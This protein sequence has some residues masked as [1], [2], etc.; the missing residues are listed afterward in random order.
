MDLK[1]GMS[2]AL[3]IEDGE[4][5]NHEAEK[6]KERLV[7]LPTFDFVFVFRMQGS[8]DATRSACR[9]VVI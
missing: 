4:E 9:F 3:E 2:V 6:R 8:G 5:Q 7:A 1:S